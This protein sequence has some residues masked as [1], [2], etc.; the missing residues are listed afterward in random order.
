MSSPRHEVIDVDSAPPRG[1]GRRALTLDGADSQGHYDDSSRSE[2]DDEQDAPQDEDDDEDDDDDAQ[3]EEHAYRRG[4]QA[5]PMDSPGDELRSDHLLINDDAEDADAAKASAGV[6]VQRLRRLRGRRGFFHSDADVRS[7]RY[8]SSGGILQRITLRRR[9]KREDHDVFWTAIGVLTLLS[10]AL[11]SCIVIYLTQTDFFESHQ[12]DLFGTT[13]DNRFTVVAQDKAQIFLKSGYS[14]TVYSEG[15]ITFDDGE[16][17][18]GRRAVESEESKSFFGVAFFPNGTSSFTHRV[19]SPMIEADYLSARKGVVFD[20]GTMMTTAANSS[21]GVKEQGDLNLVSRTGTVVTSAGG[22]SLLFVD[23]AGTV[24]VANTKSEHPRLKGITLDGTHGV[25]SIGNGLTIKHDQNVSS[26]STSRALNLDT[27]TLFVGTS[28][29]D[30]VR[31]SVP[32]AVGDNSDK[33]DGARALE[34]EEMK[35]I[36]LEV[37]GQTSSTQKEGGDVRIV[38][39]NGLDVGGDVTLIGGQATDSESS[40]GTVAINAG[41]HKAASSYTEIGSHSTTHEVNIHGLVSFNHKAGSVNDTTQVKVGGGR[42]NVS[43]Q[44]ITLDNRATSLSELHIN[45]NDVR[46][47][48]SSPSVQI[49]K[50]GLSTVKVQGASTS[51]DATKKV[52]IG[53]TA[54][55]VVIG[56]ADASKQVVKVASSVI[57]LDAS[58]SI[59]I[60]TRNTKAIT[61]ISGIVHFNGTSTTASLLSITDVAVR[62]NPPKFRVGPKGKTS[63]ASIEATHVTIGGPGAN[64]TVL[65]PSDSKLELLSSIITVGSEASEVSL[66]GKSVAVDAMETLDVGEQAD[67]VNIGGE[68]VGKVNLQ[69]EAVSLSGASTINGTSFSV[70]SMKIN[71]GSKATSDITIGAPGANIDIGAK[72]KD[73]T[74]GVASSTI[75]IGSDASVVNLY[76]SVTVNGKSLDSRRLAAQTDVWHEIKSKRFGYL[77]A[78]RVSVLFTPTKP[79]TTFA[80]QWDTGFSS[81][82]EAYQV[83]PHRERMLSILPETDNDGRA[84]ARYLQVS[85]Q[86]S[87]VV[88]ALQ[89]ENAAANTRPSKI[90]CR[91]YRHRAEQPDVIALEVSAAV[92]HCF[93]PACED[94]IF[95]GLQGQRIAPYSPGDIFST[96]CSLASNVAGELVLKDAQYSFAEQ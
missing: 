56:D 39:G 63:I 47:G 34:A 11:M 87:S 1:R 69:A 25:I 16:L 57:Q 9:K 10:F 33:D 64:A 83:D 15:M 30:K 44:R 66:I 81:E 40:Y 60:N 8:R 96:Q 22:K 61:T 31:I 18:I 71:I 32:S 62:A 67:E 65:P 19:N 14:N 51:L 24:T 91:V 41:L 42:F 78:G 13:V 21:G 4:R 23:P 27:S 48:A 94:G 54:P 26:L 75:D 55:S 92:D 36:T 6:G 12:N 95:L 93:G 88:F 85:L 53:G 90:R 80:L 59:A 17:R 7:F 79:L 3:G 43:S 89:S 68:E 20:D 82:P 28:K 70:Q 35:S 76:G 77:N 86:I 58:D 74:I 84:D 49:G 45:S 29:S 38:G 46:L 2:E 73:M 50:A 52:A 37:V 5:I 72:A